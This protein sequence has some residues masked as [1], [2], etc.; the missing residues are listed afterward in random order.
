M[1]ENGAIFSGPGQVLQVRDFHKASEET[2]SEVAAKL[3]GWRDAQQLPFPDVSED[4][5]AEIEG[6]LL[7]P[8]AGS[9]DR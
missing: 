4:R 7:Y 6:S 8:P 3:D 9:P 1:H 2:M 5:K